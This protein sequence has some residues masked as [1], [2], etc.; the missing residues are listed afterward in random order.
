MKIKSPLYYAI[1]VYCAVNIHII[2]FLDLNER[3]F[4]P[5][6]Y[7]NTCT[8]YVHSYER[9]VSRNVSIVKKKKKKNRPLLCKIMQ[10]KKASLEH[11]SNF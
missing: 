5:V 1:F 11:Y 2:Y 3:N 4:G 8:V 9:N 7:Y 6:T 10:I